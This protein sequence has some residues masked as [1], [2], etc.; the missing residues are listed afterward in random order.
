MQ[1]TGPLGTKISEL[2][3]RIVQLSSRFENV[4][5]Q[6][7]ATFE[8]LL[9]N[10]T[11]EHQNLEEQLQVVRGTVAES[12]AAGQLSIEQMETQIEQRSVLAGC[13]ERC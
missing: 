13:T 5:S 10:S 6:T 12:V 4:Q 1:D 11:T 7:S 2:E 3:Q 8:G 9:Q